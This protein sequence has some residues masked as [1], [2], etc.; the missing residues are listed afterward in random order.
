MKAIVTGANGF[1]G[2]HVVRELLAHN[3]ETIAIDL[4]DREEH[5]PCSP[6]LQYIKLDIE[7]IEL[8]VA[9]GIN[10]D[11]F[12]HF[13]WD[14]V[15]GESRADAE[16]QLKNVRTTCLCVKIAKAIGCE[17]FIYASS[18]IE[19]EAFMAC[20][21]H[22]LEP[23]VGYIYGSAKQAANHIAKMTAAE[24]GVNY[25]AGKISNTY[26]VG[27]LSPRLLNTTM[28]RIIAE[29]AVKF[30]A[31]TQNYDFVYITDVARAFRLI[32]E[33]GKPFYDYF[34]GSGSPK[35]LREFLVEMRD[36]IAPEYDFTFGDVP[37]TGV[38]V[39]IEYFDGSLIKEHC[40][41]TPDVSFTEGVQ[42]VFDWLKSIPPTPVLE[43]TYER[44]GVMKKTQSV[45]K[46]ETSNSQVKVG[47]N[48]RDFSFKSLSTGGLKVVYPFFFEDKRGYFLKNY[49]KNIFTQS[50]IK[51]NL[52]EAYESLSGKGVLRGL[53]FQSKMP[54]AK[55]IRVVSGR[56]FDV[57]VDLRRGSAT[58]GQWHG[59]E[60]SCENKKMLYIPPG[61]AHGF[62]VLSESALVSNISDGQYLKDY[63]TGIIWNDPDIGIDW[64]F[65]Q[66]SNAILSEKDKMLPTFN[67][68][69]EQYGGL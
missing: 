31:G 19:D 52:F 46:F 3:I 2:S 67:E 12:F 20:T 4:A 24:C 49:E 13:A 41:F 62:L 65:N 33:H 9:D 47:N 54:Q 45:N 60:L 51:M 61:F 28:R 22:G 69:L 7:N 21:D 48:K 16:Q 40:G 64:P 35:P 44:L 27:E 8:L 15:A 29:E 11:V 59:V 10:A 1:V 18:M 39:P 53:H 57:A 14:G 56:I 38:N 66:L 34:I 42:R 37:F 26:G 55:L 58:F 68:F 43:T 25:I 36:V 50:G 32:A 30:T 6:L 5:M 23:G 17:R 63:D